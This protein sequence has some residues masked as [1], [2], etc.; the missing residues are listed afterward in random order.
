MTK[1]F[2]TTNNQGSIVSVTD[3]AGYEASAVYDNYGAPSAG[4]TRRTGWLDR[5]RDFETS[6]LSSKHKLYDLEARKYNASRGQ[7]LS[8]DPL[9]MHYLSSGSYVYCEADPVN[10]V[11]PW[12]LGE[13]TNSGTPYPG[14]VGFI[15]PLEQPMVVAGSDDPSFAEFMQASRAAHE[16][17][18]MLMPVV[19]GNTV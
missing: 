8:V 1:R 17:A 7:F 2:V 16:A 10:M 18:F 13:V 3:N 19:N 9:W 4:Y 6:Q 11:D 5:E 15:G 14:D 12:G